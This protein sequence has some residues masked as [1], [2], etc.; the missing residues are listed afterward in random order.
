[1]IT[2]AAAGHMY[3]VVNAGCKEKDLA[4]MRAQ[5][6]AYNAK[7]GSGNEWRRDGVMG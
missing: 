2:N 7:N 3:M 4:H 5:L 1:M 6:S